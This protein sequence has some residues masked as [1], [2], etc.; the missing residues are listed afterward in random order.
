MHRN[1]IGRV[2]L[3]GMIVVAAGLWTGERS[4]R[5]VVVYTQ[6]FD[7]LPITPENTSLGTTPA[8][9]KDNDPAPPAANFS[10][11]GWYL[12]HST[13]QAEGGFSGNQRMR[14]G[15]G[16]ANTGAF[17]S[18]GASGSTERA[19]GNVGS[20]TQMGAGGQIV[21]GLRLTNNTVDTLTE[22][23]LN[24]TAEEWRDGGQTT[25]GS[26]AQSVTFGYKLA[27]ANIQDTGFTDV[28]ALGFTSP[29]FGATSGT[30][31]NGNAAANQVAVSGTVTGLEWLPGTDLWIRWS[32]PDHPSSDHGLGIDNL[33]FSAT[34]PEPASLAIFGLVGTMF[35]ARRRRA[36]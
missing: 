13:T 2:L 33:S 4:A 21:Y 5:A 7:S 30:A 27:A 11:P 36:S 22:F 8:G 15:A 29:T 1:R 16:T 32:D 12:F 19:L 6:D 9:W 26:L 14:I 20:N 34:V 35:A 28:A 24:Y 10:I 25:T 23:T 31:L 17:M 3:A 18:F